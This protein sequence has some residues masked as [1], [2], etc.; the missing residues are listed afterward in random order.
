MATLLESPPSRPLHGLARWRQLCY[1]TTVDVSDA[2]ELLSLAAEQCCV[3]FH[4]G[5]CVIAYHPPYAPDI[6][7]QTAPLNEAALQAI[8]QAE[9]R[10]GARHLLPIHETCDTFDLVTLPLT[11][12]GRNV[13]A[14]HLLDPS[15]D[16]LDDLQ[17]IGVMLCNALS[18]QQ[19]AE[20]QQRNNRKTLDSYSAVQRALTRVLTDAGTLG[21]ATPIM[22]RALCESLG[23][24]VAT[25]WS[26]DDRASVLRCTDAWCTV[27][28]LQEFVAFS[29]TAIFAP[30]EE[31]PGRVWS[32]GT[33]CWTSD[34]V[35][36]IER[37]WGGAAM[38]VR[39]RT[40]LAFP[41]RSDG[42]ICGVI[43]LQHRQERSPDH[44]LVALLSS[45][46]DQIGQFIEHRQAEATLRAVEERLRTVVANTPIMLCALGPSG[47]VTLA[48]GQ[49]LHALGLSPDQI[50][51]RSVFDDEYLPLLN[52][53]HATRALSGESFTTI[54]NTDGLVF[55]ARWN[56]LR[57]PAGAISGAICV[58]TDITEWQ[59]A[60]EARRE[61]EQQFRAIFEQAAVGIALVGLGGLWLQ[62]NQRLCDILGYALVDLQR[63]SYRDVLGSDQLDMNSPPVQR[64]LR[65]ETETFEIDR[66]WTRP[67]GISAW[68][69]L[70]V[71]LLRTANGAPKYFVVMVEDVTERKLAE[72]E[73]DRL[74]SQLRIE[75]DRL[76][77]RE[78][79]VRTQIG[80]DLHDGPVQQVAVA[81]LSVQY[82][83]RVAEHA[84]ER[85]NQALDDLHEQLQ[86]ATRDL[87]SVLYELR[88]LGI[89]EEGL[90]VVLQ[91]Y[92]SK[93]GDAQ[94]LRIHFAA[95]ANA[96]RLL[97]DHEAAVFIIVQEAL[98]NARKHSKAQDVWITIQAD[99]N[100]LTAEVRD[101][102]RGFDLAQVQAS[103]IQRGSFG[104]LNMSERAQLIGG[105]CEMRSAVGDGTSVVVR[106]PYTAS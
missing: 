17:L 14:L 21:A 11:V 95:P 81:D 32:D 9:S 35:R 50:V 89:A 24:Q 57:D 27:P 69:M 85:L 41:I 25:Y 49:R 3:G 2:R 56:P 10:L 30:N 67:D 20:L 92:L 37:P 65:G 23:W 16:A 40:A 105:A 102:G 68:I 58:A 86:R 48:E 31:L 80:R 7:V 42:A 78:V 93:L 64:L 33:P 100:A 99:A 75:R 96:R 97:P 8:A 103:Y 61:S 88:P 29:K 4:A 44:H 28:D 45:F 46:G 34:M 19:S 74:T 13:G 6:V 70:T 87:R 83:R 43:V 5:T 73:N 91:Q 59:W 62:V 71:S 54:V 66:M 52:R 60:E 106:V 1:L 104:L 76:L 63:R 18:R 101:N 53:D 12:G 94:G 84:P 15:I 72:H 47:T 82:V 26:A 77:R 51:G 22:L 98:N 55:E 79:E 90:I 38:R 36:E 39:L